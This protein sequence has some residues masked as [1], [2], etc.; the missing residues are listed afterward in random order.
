VNAIGVIPA[1]HASSR[2]PGK[3]L[4]LLCGRPLVQWVHE[5]ASRARSLDRVLVAT[6]DERIKARVDAFGGEAVLTSGEHA[7][8]T[9]R[10]AEA[11]AG[12]EADVVVNIQGDEPLLDPDWIDLTVAALVERPEADLATL[13]VPLDDE[14]AF[15]DPDVVKV[16][17]DADGRALYFSRAPVPW[18][19]EGGARP[20]PE[21]ARRHVG[22]YAYR[23]EFLL[24]FCC[25][26]PTALERLESLEQL[27]ALE[28][29]AHVRVVDAAGRTLGVDRPGDVAAVER[30]LR[31]RTVGAGRPRETD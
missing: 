15:H 17:T 5:V 29:G 14:A 31:E 30:I 22:L 9:D 18:P 20:R 12:L 26:E 28:H 4:A 11:V 6:D 10:V 21:G 13:A 16:V 1:R 27:R 7:S 8:G 25:L 3:P 23:R 2:F 19:R 24:R